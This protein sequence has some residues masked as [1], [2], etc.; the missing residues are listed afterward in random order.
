MAAPRSSRISLGAQKPGSHHLCE[1]FPWQAATWP[2]LPRK[3]C[4]THGNCTSGWLKGSTQVGWKRR[5]VFLHVKNL[6]TSLI[7]C[8]FPGAPMRWEDSRG[9]G[10]ACTWEHCPVRKALILLRHLGAL[11]GTNFLLLVLPRTSKCWPN[12]LLSPRNWSK[13]IS[14]VSHFHRSPTS[15]PQVKSSQGPKHQ[16]LCYFGRWLWD[17][18]CRRCRDKCDFTNHH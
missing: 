1:A 12:V 8:K 11:H 14:M 16:G 18:C 9:P 3:C 10:L 2:S 17:S 5:D 15:V 13:T 6:S 4:S 7:L